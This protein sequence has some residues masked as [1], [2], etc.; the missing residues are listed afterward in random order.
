MYYVYVLKSLKDNLLYIGFTSIHP[1]KRLK[2]HNKGDTKSTNPRRPFILLYYEAHTS[3]EDARRREKYFKTDKGKSS[4]KQM[5][6]SG[7]EG[8]KVSFTNTESI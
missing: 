3:E 6:R 5:I 2:E 1:Y 4:L 7:L 8:K